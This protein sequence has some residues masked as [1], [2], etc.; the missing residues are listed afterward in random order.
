VAWVARRYNGNVATP[1]QVLAN[2]DVL[3]INATAATDA[4]VGNVAMAQIQFRAL[5]NQ[6][7]TAQGS[8]LNFIVTPV[9]NTAANRVEV[10]NITVANGVAATKFTTAG[11]VSAA[12]NITGSY[13]FGNGTLLTGVSTVPDRL[14]LNS[15][16]SLVNQTE[17]QS[18]LGQSLTVNSATRYSYSVTG[19]VYKANTAATV[20]QYALGGT[21]NITQHNYATLCSSATIPNNPGYVPVMMSDRKTSNIGVAANI[22][23]SSSGQTYYNF[24]I[25]GTIDITTGGTLTPQIGFTTLPTSPTTAIG[26]AI[27]V[28]PIG[29]ITGNTVVG[30]WA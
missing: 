16:K 11:T 26:T 23:S 4:G 24:T 15:T 6:T 21:A 7:T 9:G 20:L 19:M 29:N 17:L 28:T 13:I 2:E 8:V 14:V 12:G 10:A 1:T 18:L 3:R 25:T 22:S 27:T 5:E 30:P